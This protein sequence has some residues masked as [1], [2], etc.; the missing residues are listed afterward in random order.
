LLVIGYVGLGFGT[1]EQAANGAGLVLA[2][3]IFK[4]FVLPKLSKTKRYVICPVIDMANHNSVHTCGEVSFEFFGDAYSLAVMAPV[5]RGNEIYISYGGRSNDQLLQYYG[6]LEEDNPHDVYVMPPLR[7]WNIEELE[8]ACG[9]T[10]APGRLEKLNRAGLLGSTTVSIATTTTSAT[11]GSA[12]VNANNDK[13]DEEYGNPRGGVVLTR[14]N[15]LDPAVLQ[16]LRALVS[17][18]DEWLSA[19][20]SIGNFVEPLNADNERAARLAARRAVA[21][22]LESKPT[23]LQQDLEL[24]SRFKGSQSLQ[25]AVMEQELA[26]RFRIE[27]KKVLQETMDKLVSS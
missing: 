2:A 7:E 24:L 4:D 22:E 23:T 18:Q 21:L 9:R 27:K 8:T 5:V 13:D 3:S 25:D 16:A 15:G 19:G 14:A 20:S 10:F 12:I 1:L 6:F 11:S 26:I 17:T